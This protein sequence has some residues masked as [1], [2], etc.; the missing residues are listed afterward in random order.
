MIAMLRDPVERAYSH[1]Q[2]EYARGFEDA[3]HVR[4]GARARAGAAR[5]RA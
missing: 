4:A 5:G 3:E 1:Y 2:Q